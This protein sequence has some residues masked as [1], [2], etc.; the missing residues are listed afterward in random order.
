M[1]RGRG[2]KCKVNWLC[3]LCTE[4]SNLLFTEKSNVLFSTHSSKQNTFYSLIVVKQNTELGNVSVCCAP[5]GVCSILCWCW[6]L[7]MYQLRPGAHAEATR[8][9]LC[10]HP[11]VLASR[12][13]CIH[14]YMHSCAH[15][16]MCTCI[17]VYMHSC[18]HAF[19]CTCMHQLRACAFAKSAL[20]PIH[21]CRGVCVCV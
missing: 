15:A 4:L 10:M 13:T 18:V 1:E 19:M 21:A 8:Y 7:F 5:R 9:A 20:H 11:D 6:C 14:V 3:F 2:H 16:F 17:H 12:C